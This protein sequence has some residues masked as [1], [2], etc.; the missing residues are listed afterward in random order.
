MRVRQF[1]IRSTVHHFKEQA[2]TKSETSLFVFGLYMIII[3]GLGFIFMPT[4]VL[5]MFGLKYGDDTW[6]RFVGMLASIIGA[7]YIVAVR[8]KMQPMFIW[9]VWLRYYAATFMVVMLLVGKIGT[10]VLVFAAIDVAGATWTWMTV[11]K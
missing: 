5:D 10:A 9:T 7:Y 3:V 6:I 1:N 11:K 2:M 8:L 4:T